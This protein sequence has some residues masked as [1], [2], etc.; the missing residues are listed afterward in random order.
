M[1]RASAV[2]SSVAKAREGRGANAR[3]SA[4]TSARPSR[5][6]REN[7]ASLTAGGAGPEAASHVANIGAIL[8]VRLAKRAHGRAGEAGFMRIRRP[9]DG[10][11]KLTHLLACPAGWLLPKKR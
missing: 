8:G 7:R 6:R 4:K 3:L 1:R 5:R 10:T 2:G 11:N 9:C